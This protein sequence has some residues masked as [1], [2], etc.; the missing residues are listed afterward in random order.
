MLQS[1]L[2]VFLGLSFAQN[3]STDPGFLKNSKQLSFVGARSG[4]SYFSPDGQELIFQSERVPGNPFYQIYRMNLKN[5]KTE[6]LSPGKGKTTCSWFHPSMKKAIFSSTHLD[7][8][9]K[10]KVEKEYESRKSTLKQ[11]YS[12]SYDDYFDLFEVDL[13][14]KKLKQLTKEKGYDAEASYSP[15]GKLIAFASNRLGYQGNLSPEDKKIFEQDA[16]YLMEIYI[17]NADG[18][19][20]RRLTDSKGYDGGPFFNADGTKITWRRFAPNG[21]SAEIMTMNVDGSDQKQ[22]T[23][24]GAMSWAP[25]FHP[26][27]DY[28]IFT[29]NVLGFSN[30][31]LYMVDKD[32]KNPPIRV[33]ALDN[34]DGLPVFTPD[35]KKLAW[36]HHN[37]KGESQIY[38]GDWDDQKARAALSLAPLHKNNLRLQGNFSIQDS[39]EIVGYLASERFKGRAS[40]SSE[41][42]IYSKTLAE[43]M[44]S[45]GLEPGL[46][47]GYLQSF[48]FASG[49]KLGTSESLTISV[50]DK[51]MS[52]KVGENYTPLSFSATGKF[53]EAPVVFAGYGIKAPAG[54]NQPK[55]DSYAEIDAKGKWVLM[56]R[57]IPEGVSPARRAYLNTFARLHHKALMAREAGAVGL[58]IV[59][60]PNSGAKNKIMKLR[61][62]G[63]KFAGTALPVLSISDEIAESIFKTGGNSLKSVQDD[64][65]RGE[66]KSLEL[67]NI[68]AQAI[69]DLKEEKSTGLNVVGQ[70]KV[71]GATETLVIGAHGDHL[72]QGVTGS[73]LA[74]SDEQTASHLGADDNASGVAALLQVAEAFKK[75]K[76]KLNRNILFVVWSGE[77][78]GLIGSTYFVKS[79]KDNFPKQ[80]IVGY[81]NMDMV[82]R[83]KDQLMVQ[84][85]ASASEW[86]GIFEKMA[87]KTELPLNLMSDPYVP[88]DSMAFY[89][90]SIPAIHFFTGAHAEY[91]TPRDTA[92]LINY[93]GLQKVAQFV[94]EVSQ[95]L[96][97]KQKLT[98]QKVESSKK[99]MEGRSFR[100]FIGTIPDYS[101]EGVKGVRIS[102]TSKDSPAEKS[103]LKSGDVIVEVAGTKIENLYDYV[104]IL[105]AL[106][107]NETVPLKVK[108]GE[109][110]QQLTVTPTLKE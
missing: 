53:E 12:W 99:S 7:P 18:T 34:F 8:D 35:G 55:Y 72:G 71:K 70:I 87:V 85:T 45:L 42:K 108:R 92:D 29:T 106:K 57:D 28:L 88:S 68:K 104:Y 39:K 23:K 90:Q 27:G 36:T 98:Y 3:K 54:E 41:E 102:G 65:D 89:L 37:E 13:K 26:S 79:L 80:K 69:V 44:Q 63:A 75:S 17:M 51:K 84:G 20:V 49:V 61:F 30:F 109:A 38:I 64:F 16:S 40:G 50:G 107:P 94:F 93:E 33:T 62:D 82:G 110:L 96:A 77:E 56:F 25:Y 2:A 81:L 9:L 24:L 1:I 11:K 73:S 10:S 6:L 103:G 67:K 46:K 95:E 100:V 52:L 105:Q 66:P 5:G 74:K 15:D 101:Q 91:H 32:G 47:T 97:Q 58:L 48:E 19:N 31:E 60:G 83:F 4:E 14:T 43:T 22:L 86:P 76:L 59:N 21:Q 78:I